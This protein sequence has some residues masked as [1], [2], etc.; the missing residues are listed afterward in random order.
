MCWLDRG[1]ATVVVV[2]GQRRLAMRPLVVG[3]GV[4]AGRFAGGEGVAAGRFAGGEGVAAGRLVAAPAGFLV[5]VV[6]VVVRRL[7]GAPAG[8]LAAVVVV[9]VEGAAVRMCRS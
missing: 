2:V 8:F 3:E 1:R 5:V 9:V 7:V 6:V 4:A